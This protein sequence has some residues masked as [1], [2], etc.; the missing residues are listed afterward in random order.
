MEV[1]EAPRFPQFPAGKLHFF[2]VGD[3]IFPLKNW[4]MRPYPGKL[5]LS[6]KGFNNRPRARRSIE[7]TFGILAGRWRILRQR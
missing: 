3:E 7:N 6:Q 5:V 1:P 4:L 2:L